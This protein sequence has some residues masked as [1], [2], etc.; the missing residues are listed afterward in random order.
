MI[1]LLGRGLD[2]CTP[3]GHDRRNLSPL[4]LGALPGA[5]FVLSTA[6]G[7]SGDGRVVVGQSRS[8]IGRQAFR[9]DVDS[10]IEGL[11]FLP[12]DTFSSASSA[13][14]D[15]STIV[16]TSGLLTGERS[17]AFIW[18]EEDG[19]QDLN[20]FLAAEG[21]DLTGWTLLQANDISADGLTIVGTGLNPLNQLEGFFVVIPEPSSST[22]R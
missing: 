22:L 16:G 4:L 5:R 3:L 2:A 17:A 12:N 1:R 11:G 10:A 8:G 9:W 21:V 20:V 6:V 7:V 13:S 19:M 15:G 14:E 18:T